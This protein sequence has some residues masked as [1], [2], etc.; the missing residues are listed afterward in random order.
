MDVLFVS[1]LV[2]DWCVVKSEPWWCGS[3]FYQSTPAGS[4]PRD[5]RTRWISCK[6]PETATMN[7]E[8]LADQ[9]IFRKSICSCEYFQVIFCWCE[10]FQ[11]AHD[12]D[13]GPEDEE[14]CGQL[15][16]RGW[17]WW[18][19]SLV[20]MMMI[21]MTMMLVMLMFMTIMLHLA[22][23]WK[24]SPATGEG[25]NCQGSVVTGGPLQKYILIIRNVKRSLLRYLELYWF[26]QRWCLGWC[27]WLD[28]CSDK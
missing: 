5:L 21:M 28:I 2:W 24:A 13:N 23:D 22:G 9:D 10:Q 19:L 26:R 16:S 6:Y 18:S 27:C 7:I 20:T 14:P 25:D 1:H 12:N 11:D 3:P 4:L 8:Y 17:W 15:K